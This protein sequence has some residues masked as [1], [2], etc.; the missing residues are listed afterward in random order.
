AR[1]AARQKDFAAA[2]Q[3]VESAAAFDD[4]PWPVDQHGLAAAVELKAGDTAA[5]EERLARARAAV[6]PLVVAFLMLDEGARR[7]LPPAVKKRFDK[8]VKDGLAAKADAATAGAL[9]RLAVAHQWNEGPYHGAKTHAKKVL[10]YIERVPVDELD[11]MSGRWVGGGMLELAPPRNVRRFT[12]A[13][14]RRFP[15]DPFFPHMEANSYF[16]DR[17]PEGFEMYRVRQLLDEVERLAKASSDEQQREVILRDVAEKRRRL[18]EA[19]DFF[20]AFDGYGP[21]GGPMDDI[22]DED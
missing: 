3:H 7:Q 4:S 17:E 5:A 11:T 14:R 8:E 19:G 12:E 22:D 2:R 15:T 9:A 1:L 13:A 16:R 21:F 6:P 10:G 20:S 18:A